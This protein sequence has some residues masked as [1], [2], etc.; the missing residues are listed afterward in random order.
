MDKD[1]A[2]SIAITKILDKLQ[3]RPLHVGRTKAL[4]RSPISK[5]KQPS[6]WLYFKTNTWYDYGIPSGGDLAELVWRYLKFTGEAYTPVD[7]QRWIANMAKDGPSSQQLDEKISA[8]SKIDSPILTI[9]SM[10]PLKFKGLIK[11]LEG[12]GISEPLASRYA[13]ELKVHNRKTGKTFIAIGVPNEDGGYELHNPVFTGFI[14]PRGVTF[15]VEQILHH[16][17]SI[18]LRPFLT[19]CRC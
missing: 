18:F 12:L 4:Y 11:Y 15:S 19:S 14:Q 3:I 17:A 10:E 16:A 8:A 7:V 6:F 1:H 9:K 2:N 5:E 13:K